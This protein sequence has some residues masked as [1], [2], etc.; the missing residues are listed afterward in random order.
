MC[1]SACA[2]CQRSIPN[3]AP[4]SSR[5]RNTSIS[6]SPYCDRTSRSDIIR[7]KLKIRIVPIAI[8]MC[9]VP[10]I[11]C[12]Q[13]QSCSRCRSTSIIVSPH[14]IGAAVQ[15]V[16]AK[17]LK[18]NC[19][20][21]HVPSATNRFSMG[22]PIFPRSETHRSVPLPVAIGPAV[23][24][25]FAKGL[26]I[27]IVPIAISMCQVPPIDFPEAPSSSQGGNTSISASPIPM[28]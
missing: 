24:T 16:F 28:P 12:Q 5:G 6:A 19:T 11:A 18:I 8:G 9:Q 1:Q 27:R 17:R 4:S 25:L 13:A 22:N 2:K 10:P 15:T 26:K 21:C 14:P 23:R 20:N 3:K 7:E